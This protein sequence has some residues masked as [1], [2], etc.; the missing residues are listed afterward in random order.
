MASPDLTF[1]DYLKDAFFRRVRVPLLGSLPFNPMA[2]GVFAV[3]GLANPG[4]WLLGA[5]AEVTYLAATAGNGRYQKLVQGERLLAVQRDWE[6]TVQRAVERLKPAARARYQHLLAQCRLIL[7][8]ADTL[9]STSLGNFRDLR[10]RSLN[11]LLGIFLRLLASRDVIAENVE[12]LNRDRLHGDISRLERSLA[13]AGEN[14]ALARSLEGTLAIQKKRLENHEKA[15]SS[16]RV[17]DA[18]LAR[19]EQQVELIREEAAVSGSPEFLSQRLD[20]V[21]ATMGETSRWMDEHASLLTGMA[22]EDVPG[23]MPELPRLPEV[24]KEA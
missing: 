15:L 9:D 17:I 18:E 13:D 10:A 11:Q 3:L 19:I 4:F 24:E 22:A 8:L 16:L 1:W 12:G 21:T 20:T 2:L 14:A 7:G 23:P 5:A 6:T